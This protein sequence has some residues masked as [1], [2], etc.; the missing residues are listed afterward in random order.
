MERD[1]EAR[2]AFRF[3]DGAGSFGVCACMWCQQARR[4]LKIVAHKA[5]APIPDQPQC[6]NE[7]A[8]LPSFPSQ[9]RRELRSVGDRHGVAPITPS[10]HK[11]F[12]RY[13]SGAAKADAFDIGGVAA[14][15]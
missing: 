10:T 6:P 8:A 7:F 14:K 3:I 12:A 11:K 13:Q 1:G 2:W 5:E 15:A 9:E 4:L